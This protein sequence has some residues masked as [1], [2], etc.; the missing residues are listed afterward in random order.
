MMVFGVDLVVRLGIVNLPSHL[1][2]P[3]TIILRGNK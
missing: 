1:A 2:S 3:M